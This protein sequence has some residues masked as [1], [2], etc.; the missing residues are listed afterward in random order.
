MKKQILFFIYLIFCALI[1]GQNFSTDGKILSMNDL[2][3]NIDLISDLKFLNDEFIIRNYDIGKKENNY[4]VSKNKINLKEDSDLSFITTD[5]GE[6]Y[7]IL[8]SQDLI[9]LYEKDCKTPK[10]FGTHFSSESEFIEYINPD[11]VTASSE[12]KENNYVYSGKNVCNLNLNEPWVE[13]IKGNGIGETIQFYGN[14]TYLYFF[15]GYVSFEKPYLYKANSRVKKISISFP[16]NKLRKNI[17]V[18]LQDSPNPQKIDLGFRCTDLIEI[19]I[20][21][22]YEGLKYDDTCVLGIVMKVY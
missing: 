8:A 15:N 16:E 6:K 3:Y 18:E 20:L 5:S 10:I 14:C 9:V 21:E 12:L 19:K 1:Y 13:S 22:V 2:Y 4:V 7:L 17:E 11:C